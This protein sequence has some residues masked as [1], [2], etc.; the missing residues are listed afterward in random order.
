MIILNILAHVIWLLT[1]GKTCVDM[2]CPIGKNMEKYGRRGEG[3]DGMPVSDADDEGGQGRLCRL[4]GSN[5]GCFKDS[6]LEKPGFFWLKLIEKPLKSQGFCYDRRMDIH[7]MFVAVNSCQDV[8]KH[9]SSSTFRQKNPMTS[10]G[11]TYV[12]VILGNQ[13][14][15]CE[16]F[17]RKRQKHGRTTAGWVPWLVL[18]LLV[19]RIV[20]NTVCI[21]IWSI[22]WF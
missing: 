22:I 2:C 16:D 1:C 13:P 6:N 18:M 5:L 4:D 15:S 21:P 17:S 8:H 11:S 12:E 20:I 7:P 19:S 9:R 3:A 14:P 10:P